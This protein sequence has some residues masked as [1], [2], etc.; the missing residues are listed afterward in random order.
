MSFLSRWGFN[1]KEKAAITLLCLALVAGFA[2]NEARDRIESRSLNILTAEDSA[3]IELLQAHT[4]AENIAD[5]AQAASYS[6]PSGVS[7]PEAQ[8]PLD[9]NSASQSELEALPGIGPVLAERIIRYREVKGGFSA[10]DSLVKVKGIGEG[11]LKQIKNKIE[12]TKPI[13]EEK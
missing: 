8:F 6:I 10:I 7:M 1:R 5:S 3:A 11:K 12:I 4:A 9:I 2:V 13:S